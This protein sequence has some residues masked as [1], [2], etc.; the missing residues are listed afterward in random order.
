MH[1]KAIAEIKLLQLCLFI[2]LRLK[3]F[4]FYQNPNAT[5]TETTR[6]SINVQC[7]WILGRNIHFLSAKSD[8]GQIYM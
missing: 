3:P 1:Y 5:H 4:Y 7:T 2:T 8:I 6:Y